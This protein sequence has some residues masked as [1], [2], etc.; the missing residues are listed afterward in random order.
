MSK[1]KGTTIYLYSLNF[2]LLDTF[3]SSRMAVKYLIC[4]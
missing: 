1:V 4:N 2:K 3:T